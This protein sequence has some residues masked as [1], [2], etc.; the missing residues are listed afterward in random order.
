MMLTKP[1][2]SEAAPLAGGTAPALQVDG[3]S[4][5]FRS[6]QALDGVSFGVPE[7]SMTVLLGPAGAGKTTTLRL[8]A[9]LDRLDAGVITMRGRDMAG[10][11]PKD[12]DIAMIFD[13][14]ALYPNKSGLENIAYPLSLRGLSRMEAKARAA[15]MAKTLHIS[16]VLDRL[17]KTMSGGE[18]QRVALGRALVRDPGLF[19]LDEPLSSLDAM[20]RIELRAELKRLQREISS[21]FLLATPDFAEAMAIADRVIMLRASRVVQIAD[22]QTL[23]DYPA[24]RETARFVGAPEINL[25]AARFEPAEGGR[26]HLAGAAMPV[27]RH[28]AAALVK[29][30]PEFEAG[31]RPEHLAL[32]EPS[33]A[34]ISAKVVDIEPLGLKSTLTVNNANAELR[35]VLAAAAARKLAPGDSVSLTLDLN[36]ISAFDKITGLRIA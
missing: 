35:L 16:H 34:Q 28:L 10:L 9:G 7:A 36:R 24:D 13:N 26:I 30:A 19:L 23:Y 15:E 20:L 25:V 5:R 27:P 8:I 6:T 33:T 11:Q 32:A 3:L 17:P 12:R 29:A 21:T 1:D 22:P 31:I 2:L 4:K 14:L 18:R